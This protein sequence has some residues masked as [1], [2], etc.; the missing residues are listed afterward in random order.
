MEEAVV[1]ADIMHIATVEGKI[2]RTEILLPLPA[3]ER[4]AGAETRARLLVGANIQQIQ[5]HG[6]KSAVFIDL[7]GVGDIDHISQRNRGK[8]CGRRE[9]DGVKMIPVSGQAQPQMLAAADLTLPSGVTGLTA[10]ASGFMR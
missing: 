4:L 2:G 8:L 1:D 6:A 3:V 7:R 10:S 5:L 9:E